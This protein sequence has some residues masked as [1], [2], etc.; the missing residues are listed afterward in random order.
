MHSYEL[1]LP[2]IPASDT[3]RIQCNSLEWWDTNNYGNNDTD[4][5]Q[6][7]QH[8]GES[9]A[10]GIMNARNKSRPR[11]SEMI[12]VESDGRPLSPRRYTEVAPGGG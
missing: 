6:Q 4:I 5:E 3:F 11:R 7:G 1:H 2:E 10:T 9:L 12:A 8:N